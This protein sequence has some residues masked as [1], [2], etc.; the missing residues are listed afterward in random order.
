MEIE[1]QQRSSL[2]V[3][4]RWYLHLNDAPRRVNAEPVEKG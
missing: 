3:V 1:L 4:G 2:W